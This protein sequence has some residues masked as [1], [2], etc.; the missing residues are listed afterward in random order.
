MTRTFLGGVLAGLGGTLLGMYYLPTFPS[1][2]SISSLASE[3]NIST[4]GTDS[5]N[6]EQNVHIE[7]AWNVQ[8]NGTY[9]TGVCS[10]RVD[11]VQPE[12]HT[13]PNPCPTCIS[14]LAVEEFYYLE[15]TNGELTRCSKCK[16]VVGNQ[17]PTSVSN[18]AVASADAIIEWSADVEWKMTLA[19]VCAKAEILDD[20][21]LQVKTDRMDASIVNSET[22]DDVLGS[23]FKN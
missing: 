16:F 6:M 21:P 4:L 13:I 12:Q 14:E 3:N 18:I 8:G 10:A 5:V 22:A 19:P 15:N 17:E 1:D 11:S 2:S 9:G 7:D 23:N 20:E